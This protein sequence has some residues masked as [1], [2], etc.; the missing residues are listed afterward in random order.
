MNLVCKSVNTDTLNVHWY[1]NVFVQIEQQF[2]QSANNVWRK[3]YTSLRQR[4]NKSRT[5]SNY[6]GQQSGWF[7][8]RAKKGGCRADKPRPNL[9]QENQT[10]VSN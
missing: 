5:K 2:P 6:K 3:V 10:K 4:P 9:G 8:K 7:P 1:A